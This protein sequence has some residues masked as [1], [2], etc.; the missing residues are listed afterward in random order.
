MPFVVEQHGHVRVATLGSREPCSAWG[1][2]FHG[3]I[4]EC[5]PRRADDSRVRAVMVTGDEH[6]RAVSAGANLKDLSANSDALP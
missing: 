3:C 6:R 1:Q 5:F 2:D 4:A